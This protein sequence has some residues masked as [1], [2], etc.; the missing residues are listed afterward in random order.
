[1]DEPK[2]IEDAE[3]R[4]DEIAEVTKPAI[5]PSGSDHTTVPGASPWGLKIEGEEYNRTSEAVW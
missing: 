5:S 1:M 2:T 3:R 4:M